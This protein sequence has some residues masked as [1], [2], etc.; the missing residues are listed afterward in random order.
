MLFFIGSNLQGMIADFEIHTCVMASMQSVDRY[1][2]NAYVIK[3]ALL[4]SEIEG[5]V[6]CNKQNSDV[7]TLNRTD[8]MI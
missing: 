6:D 2:V 7:D 1:F 3:E 4:S 8:N 5:I